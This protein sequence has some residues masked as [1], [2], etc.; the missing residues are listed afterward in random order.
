MKHPARDPQVSSISQ[1]V[2]TQ[3]I[4]FV[5]FWRM[6]DIKDVNGWKTQNMNLNKQ[7]TFN[8]IHVLVTLS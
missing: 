5:V 2:H 6:N 3:I 8:N 4:L 1:C 7:T